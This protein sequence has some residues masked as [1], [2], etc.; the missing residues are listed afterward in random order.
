MTLEQYIK[1]DY[2]S[3]NEEYIR[4]TTPFYYEP[5]VIYHPITNGFGC[6]REGS[7]KEVVI[8][9]ADYLA[10]GERYI[11]I[12]EVKD[13]SHNYSA[14]GSIIHKQLKRVDESVKPIG[15]E[16]PNSKRIMYV[17]HNNV[18]YEVIQAYWREW[19]KKTLGGRITVWV[20]DEHDNNEIIRKKPYW[21][22]YSYFGSKWHMKHVK[23][24]D[25]L[26]RE[27][28]DI[29]FNISVRE[30]KKYVFGDSDVKLKCSF[31]K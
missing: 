3:I 7:K 16:I 11:S 1:K 9:N 21:E 5:N 18:I 31:F 27:D 12:Q 20:W 24:Y 2:P 14:T 30:F 4:L 15:I 10:N 26:M 8:I 13:K 23:S 6:G 17:S 29:K 22:L 28:Y 19:E 25:S